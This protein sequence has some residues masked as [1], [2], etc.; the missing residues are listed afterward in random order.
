MPSHG[1]RRRRHRRRAQTP[2]CSAGS[3]IAKIIPSAGASPR[4]HPSRTIPVAPPKIPRKKKPLFTLPRVL[5][6]T[7]NPSPTPLNPS[8]AQESMPVFDPPPPLPA[9]PRQRVLDDRERRLRRLNVI[10]LDRLPLEL[11]V[12]LEEPPKH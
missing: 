7:P 11:L 4:I 1:L 8:P 6:P 2:G 5:P 3:D 9:I 12:V 10:H